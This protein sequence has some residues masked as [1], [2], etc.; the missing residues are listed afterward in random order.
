MTTAFITLALL[1]CGGG[2]GKK[3]YFG[4]LE[5]GSNVESPFKVSMKA[6]NLIVE[7]ATMGV[8]EGH[9]HFHIIVD[10]SLASPSEPMSKDEKHIHYGNGQSEALLDLPVGQ[11]TLILQFAKG[12][13]VPYDP[14][15]YQQIQVNVTKQ[16]VVDTAMA[17]PGD[18]TA[19][20][21]TPVGAAANTA[22]T[23]LPP[24]D[25]SKAAKKA[26]A[27]DNKKS[28]SAKA[29]AQKHEGHKKEK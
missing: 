1:A 22:T 12:D 21:G 15:L 2:G 16:N 23:R 18:S 29:E 19:S 28:D 17:K 4:N 25:T 27:V 13:H 24:A 14:P 5:D 11:H 6:E 10:A 20:A 7:P 3:V 26:I 8:T 9:G